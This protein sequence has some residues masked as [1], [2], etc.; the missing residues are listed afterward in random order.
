MGKYL[1]A[2]VIVLGMLV[3]GFALVGVAMHWTQQTPEE[4]I[5]EVNASGHMT[6]RQADILS[7]EKTSP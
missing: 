4:I 6:D 2:V 1:I 3:M 5:E 7:K